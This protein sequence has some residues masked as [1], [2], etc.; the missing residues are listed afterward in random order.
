MVIS[1]D[2]LTI[3]LKVSLSISEDQDGYAVSDNMK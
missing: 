3:Q 2:E 1:I